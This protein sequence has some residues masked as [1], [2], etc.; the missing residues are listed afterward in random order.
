MNPDVCIISLGVIPGS[1]KFW[2]KLDSDVKYWNE[3]LGASEH[4][5]N[6]QEEKLYTQQKGLALL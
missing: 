6:W 3:H 4:V 5:C 1:I 2:Q